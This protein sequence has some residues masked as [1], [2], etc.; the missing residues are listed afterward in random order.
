M[1][2]DSTTDEEEGK[3]SQLNEAMDKLNS[4]LSKIEQFKSTKEEL[5]TE[6]GLKPKNIQEDGKDETAGKKPCTKSSAMLKKG[7]GKELFLHFIPTRNVSLVLLWV[8]LD[9]FVVFATGSLQVKETSA[10]CTVNHRAS[11][12]NYQ[13]SNIEAPG[14][15]FE[16]A[17]SEVGGMNSNRYNT[18]PPVLLWER[19]ICNSSRVLVLACH[20][21]DSKHSVEGTALHIH[22]ME[23]HQLFL[24]KP[25]IFG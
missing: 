6:T 25:F 19:R 4:L 7:K 9:L 24:W 3:G 5:V 21:V 22:K 14:P 12:S 11:T 2:P 1:L 15:R 23:M 18:E 20:L 8:R 13:L 10:Y 17:A 16:P